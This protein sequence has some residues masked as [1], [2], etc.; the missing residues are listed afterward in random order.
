MQTK[1]YYVAILFLFI[2][3]IFVLF[4]VL[5]C[6]RRWF[7]K[8]RSAA[9]LEAILDNN[10]RSISIR[11]SPTTVVLDRNQS[12]FFLQAL[13]KSQAKQPLKLAALNRM[14]HQ[15][16]LRIFFFDGKTETYKIYAHGVIESDGL[17]WDFDDAK[18]LIRWGDLASPNSP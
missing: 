16:E 3:I 2:S 17:C 4:M 11:T 1:R 6:T 5:F 10:I 14:L 18:I 12:L 15:C 8:T 9:D 7:V 13:E